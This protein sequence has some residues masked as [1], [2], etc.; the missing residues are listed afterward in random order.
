VRRH[1]LDDALKGQ[2]G[3]IRTSEEFDV[4]PDAML[5][6]AC[7]MGLEGIIAK[8]RDRPYRS[9][10]TGDWIK[11]KCIQSD[12]FVAVGY[13]PSTA[14]PGAIVSLLAAPYRDGYVY[15]GSVGTGF[16]QDEARALKKTL[17][18]LKIRLPPVHVPGKNLVLASPTL[19]A[20]I[21]Y[22]ASTND[23]K[24]RHPSYRACESSRTM[25]T[26]TRWKIRGSSGSSRA[27]RV[28]RIEE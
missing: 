12:A 28:H 21:Q 8:H 2:G 23:R 14:V 9:G 20:E 6:H 5:E 15:V 7:Q 25:L 3:A 18:K 10:R 19:I 26:S 17:D 24:L 27:P 13:E 22:R 16:K 4:D 11:I 1:L